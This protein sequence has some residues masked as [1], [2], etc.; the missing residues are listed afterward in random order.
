MLAMQRTPCEVLM[1]VQCAVDALV[2]SCQVANLPVVAG[3]IVVE[4]VIEIEEGVLLIRTTNVMSAVVGAI[5]RE[6]VANMVAT[7]AEAIL[8]VVLAVTHVDID[9][10]PDRDHALV[11][12]QFRW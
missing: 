3:Q 12:G 9:R 5:M 8:V 6:I 2:L 7:G 4:V 10:D 1:V 11:V